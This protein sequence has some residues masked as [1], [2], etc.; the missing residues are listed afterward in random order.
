MSIYQRLRIWNRATRYL[1]KSEAAECHFALACLRPGM[2]AVDIG[3]HKAAYTYWLSKSVG[4]TG[5][6][7]AYEPVPILANYLQQYAESCRNRN[8]RVCPVALSDQ[9]GEARLKIPRSDYCWSTLQYQ[10]SE[11]DSPQAGFSY[12]RVRMDTLDDHLDSIRAKRPIGFVKCDVEGHEL[13]VLRGAQRTLRQDRP[14]LLLES[15]PLPSRSADEN[16]AF[17]L[18][19]ELGYVGYFFFQS[20]LIGLEEYDE[21]QHPLGDS[22]VQNF[23]FMHPEAWTLQN[24]RHPFQV[25]PCS[26][27]RRN[28]KAA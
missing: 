11:V 6:V 8:I 24:A 20:N 3:A 21:A 2:N 13:S 12:V 18:L 15:T 7:F 16:E 10:A 17:G 23:V 1:H 5:Q 9:V 27:S 14:S 28:E 26:D 19:A 25:E 22:S 4:K